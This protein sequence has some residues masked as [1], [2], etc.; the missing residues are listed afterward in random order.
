MQKQ[1]TNNHEPLMR[2]YSRTE[3]HTHTQERQRCG[4][5]AYQLRKHS[6]GA[7]ESDKQFKH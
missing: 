7:I 6:S 3:A 1:D 4:Q 5:N 2:C